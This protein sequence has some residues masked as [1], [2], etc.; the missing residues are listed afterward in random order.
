MIQMQKRKCAIFVR[1]GCPD[2]D[3]QATAQIQ[4]LKDFAAKSKMP[5]VAEYFDDGSSSS[6]TSSSGEKLL[7][8]LKDPSRKWNCVLVTDKTR[9]ARKLSILESLESD[10]KKHGVQLLTAH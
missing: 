2:R 9:L 3:Q 7:T 6:D 5:I 10:F 1:V 8:D 4:E